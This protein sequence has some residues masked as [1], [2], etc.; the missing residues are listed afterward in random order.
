MSPRNPKSPKVVWQQLLLFGR[1]KS[2]PHEVG[3]PTDKRK[4][5]NG[6]RRD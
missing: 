5:V 6:G 2:V 1:R 3:Y 4:N